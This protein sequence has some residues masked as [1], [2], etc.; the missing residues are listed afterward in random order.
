M[1][2]HRIQAE[3]VRQNTNNQIMHML[4]SQRSDRRASVI[5]VRQNI[6]PLTTISPRRPEPRPS[7][8]P[9]LSTH[10]VRVEGEAG[11]KRRESSV[12]PEDDTTEV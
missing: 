6:Q 4:A 12:I 11:S 5:S 2:R 7:R 9:G 8:G 3:Y 10:P 1:A